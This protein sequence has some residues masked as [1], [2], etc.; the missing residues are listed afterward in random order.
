MNAKK[1]F[2]NKFQNKVTLHG[3]IG[4]FETFLYKNIILSIFFWFSSRFVGTLPQNHTLGMYSWFPY[5]IPLE[6]LFFK[7]CINSLKTF[8]VQLFFS[9]T[10]NFFCIFGDGFL[11][12][13]FGMNGP[14]RRKAKKP[15]MKK[16][17]KK[18]TTSMGRVIESKC[19]F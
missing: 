12:I 3:F 2:C 15:T 11:I 14:S 8:S 4:F 10:K 7:K 5:F 9:Q 6:V 16:K 1:V 19:N 13:V 17:L 18:F